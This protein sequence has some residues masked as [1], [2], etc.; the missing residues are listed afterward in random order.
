M[1]ACMPSHASRGM[2]MPPTLRF[3]S[4]H[5]PAVPS[6]KLVFPDKLLQ[7]RPLDGLRADLLTVAG[8][9]V[10]V[11]APCLVGQQQHPGPIRACSCYSAGFRNAILS[12]G[13]G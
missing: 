10:P 5:V 13:P 11:L 9:R 6:W 2:C 12:S 8:A 4:L 3:L 1:Q 7:F